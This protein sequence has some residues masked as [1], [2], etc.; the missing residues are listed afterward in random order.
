MKRSIR[1]GPQTPILG[2]KKWDTMCSGEPLVLFEGVPLH[3]L[4]LS[5]GKKKA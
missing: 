1:F 4:L 2:G 5:M 3:D